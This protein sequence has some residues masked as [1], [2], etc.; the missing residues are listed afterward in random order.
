M[1]SCQSPLDHKLINLQS[2][3]E[4]QKMKEN[5]QLLNNCP[6]ERIQSIL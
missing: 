4:E 2:T 5:F 6:H 1:V 3:F